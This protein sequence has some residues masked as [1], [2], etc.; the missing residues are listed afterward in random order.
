MKS[1][2]TIS[3]ILVGA[4]VFMS[5][6]SA[7][8]ASANAQGNIKD[9]PYSFTFAKTTDQITTG[10]EGKWDYTS[11]Y[12]NNYGSVGVNA[13]VFA[14][15]TTNNNFRLDKDC[16]LYNNTFVGSNTVRYL[17]NNVKESGYNS[18]T[19]LLTPGGS[20]RVTTSGVWSP[21]SI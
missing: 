14:T 16:T 9:R 4:M 15:N 17:E 6:T 2:K 7:G 12:I 3:K 21:D 20:L 5:V 10:S 18:C 1:K 8:M 13:R 19:L 11:C